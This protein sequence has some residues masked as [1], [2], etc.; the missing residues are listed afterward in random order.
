MFGFEWSEIAVI[1]VVA[2]ICIGPK[3]MPV[4]IR[5]ITRTIKK[6]RRMASEFQTHVDDMLREADL[7]EVSDT[8]RD[9]RS[10]SVRGAITRAMDPDGSI[11]RHIADPF[12][13]RPVPPVT[14]H[15][16]PDR[17]IVTASGP[18][19]DFLPPGARPPALDPAFRACLAQPRLRAATSRTCSRPSLECGRHLSHAGPNGGQGRPIISTTSPCRCSSI[20]SSCVRALLLVSHRLRVML[21]RQLLFQQADLPVPGSPFG[22]HT[23]HE[24]RAAAPD[25]HRALRGLLSPTSRSLSSALRS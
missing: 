10:L 12:T 2:L 14:E 5:A 3:D 4:A 1:A 21:C 20:W 15:N 9:M 7:H 23:G 24:G 8:I 13:D 17:P 6:M 25:L 18:P 16:I 19:P 22:A 11:T